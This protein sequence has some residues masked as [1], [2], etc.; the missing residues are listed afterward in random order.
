MRRREAGGSVLIDTS[1]SMRLGTSQLE[2]IISA[3]PAATLVATY[4]GRDDAGELRIVVRDGRRTD[5]RQLKPAGRGNIVDV[6]AL[7]WLERQRP[8]RVWISD[9]HVTG[10][11]DEPSPMIDRACRRLCRRANITRVR[12]AEQAA[13]ALASGR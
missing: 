6:P 9:G 11:G 13:R 8:P 7:E 2:R 12:N 1:G 3:A 4:S 10:V 5:A